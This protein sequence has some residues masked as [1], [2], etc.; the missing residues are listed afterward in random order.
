MTGYLL[1]WALLL[2]LVYGTVNHW[3]FA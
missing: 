2:V 1:V 3:P